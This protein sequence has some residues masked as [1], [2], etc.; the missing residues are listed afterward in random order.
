MKKEDLFSASGIAIGEQTMQGA[1]NESGSTL[2]PVIPHATTHE[3]YDPFPSCSQPLNVYEDILAELSNDNDI[4]QLG[5]DTFKFLFEPDEPIPLD[6]VLGLGQEQTLS[7]KKNISLEALEAVEGELRQ[8]LGDIPA[9]SVTKDTTSIMELTTNSSENVNISI[10][11][12]VVSKA[13]TYTAGEGSSRGLPQELV[14]SVGVVNP[15][16]ISSESCPNS[17]LS[18]LPQNN[19]NFWSAGPDAWCHSSGVNSTAI[20]LGTIDPHDPPRAGASFGDTTGNSLAQFQSCSSPSFPVLPYGSTSSSSNQQFPR[21][22]QLGTTGLSPLATPAMR[23][24]TW[25]SPAPMV[26]QYNQRYLWPRSPSLTD[27]KDFVQAWE[28]CLVGKIDWYRAS[29]NIQAKALRRPTSPVTLTVQWSSKLDI[30]LFIPKKAVHHTM[31]ICGGP[32]GYMFFYI[33]EFNNLDLYDHLMSKNLCAKIV[34]PSQTL[35]LSTTESK[36]H[37]L[38]TLFPG[39]MV[40]VEPMPLALES[41]S[42]PK[43]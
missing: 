11:P 20:R 36:C 10:A 31:R 37:F 2:S 1:Q 16:L 12:G 40:F 34:L 27:F 26:P 25:A 24:N 21:Y 14:G 33:T 6:D 15:I 41:Q 22:H 8:V 28:G 19:A 35:I 30:A 29:L 13:F 4:F 38:G 18:L 3:R 42:S 39:D 5:E 43:S 17:S 23:A 32:I 9:P 7:S